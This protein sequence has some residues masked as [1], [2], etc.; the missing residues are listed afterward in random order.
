LFGV[1]A[2]AEVTFDTWCNALHP[3]DR[4]RAVRDLLDASEHHHEFNADYRVVWPD[5]T[6]RWIVDR[7]R[8]TYDEHGRPISMAG[9]NVDITRRKQAE[10]RAQEL[11]LALT[12]RNAELEAERARWQGVVEG[13]ADE[14]WVCDAR[15]KISLLNL[16]TATHMG[17]DEFRGKTYAEVLE[18]VDILYTDGRERPAEQAPLLRS[19]RGEI[20][21]GEEIMR[22]RTSGKTRHRQFSSAPMRDGRG[23]ITGSVAIVRDISDAKE[24]EQ[25]L[26]LQSTAL[27]AAANSIV[28]TDHEGVILWCNPAFTEMTG[29]TA[30]EVQGRTPRVLSSGR[31]EAGFYANMWKTI[32]AGSVWSGEVVNRRKNGSLYVEEMTITPVRSDHG[33][34]THFIAI[35]VDVSERKR[36]EQAL[37]RSEKLAATGRL[38]AII[39]HEI[40]NP[41]EAMTN[42]LYL[43]GP[44]VTDPTAREYFDLLKKQLQAVSRIASQTLNFH[45]ENSQPANFNLFEVIGE[46]LEFYRPKAKKHGVTLT[47]CLEAN[48]RIVGFAGE[49]RQVVSNL[50]LNG[51]EAIAG[52]GRIAVH[53]HESFDWRDPQRRGY[54]ISVVDSGC[55]ID[56]QH[57]SR[58]FEPF[59]TTKGEKGTGLGLWV[60][61][62]IVQ[63]AGGSMRVWSSRRP[64]RSGTCFS[65]F[66]PAEVSTS[67]ASG[68]RQSA[69]VPVPDAASNAS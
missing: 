43:I 39:A 5:G 60:S 2:E 57:R 16:P 23:A 33:E 46:S 67:T 12:Q 28:I 8:A 10:A 21:R 55:G 44:S 32:L 40:N 41:L 11:N 65:V 35:K 45:R 63:R 17:L 1:D 69:T 6:V 30:E 56:P 26:Q 48:A 52:S 4:E 37:I 34:I 49:I 22:H 64:G 14:V 36:A 59:F 62:G 51:I 47:G 18:E 58:I 9:V 13:I 20:V 42:L 68:R 7:G 66:L 29:Y 31:H 27:E 38:A 50:L 54:R 53:L 15:G 25:Q 19:L 24:A 61:F 3:E